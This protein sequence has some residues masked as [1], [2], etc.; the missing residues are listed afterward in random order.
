MRLSEGFVLLMLIFA[1]FLLNVGDVGKWRVD[2]KLLV[3]L[4]VT[5]YNSK[6]EPESIQ[7]S[8]QQRRAK[9]HEYRV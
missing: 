2:K 6:M 7:K 8:Y 3:T 1:G 4:L 5:F 9:P